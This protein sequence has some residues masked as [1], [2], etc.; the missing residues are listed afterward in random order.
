MSVPVASD[1]AGTS[2]VALL[3]VSVVAA[4]VYVPLVRIIEPVGVGFPLPP[5]TA[6]VTDTASAV[7]TLDED[8]V[9]TTVG[10]GTPLMLI[11]V[12]PPVPLPGSAG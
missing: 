9:T 2:I 1:P 8:G 6:T 5:L 4:D 7:V 12:T 3:L 11:I 10:A